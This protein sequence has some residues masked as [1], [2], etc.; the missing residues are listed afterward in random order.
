MAAAVSSAGPHGEWDG[1]GQ[2]GQGEWGSSVCPSCRSRHDAPGAV[3][4]KDQGETKRQLRALRPAAPPERA[5]EPLPGC[6]AGL[7][8]LT[9]LRSALAGFH[10][11]GKR[12]NARDTA[13]LFRWRSG[14]VSNLQDQVFCRRNRNNKREEWKS[15]LCET[16]P[17]IL[18]G[19][20]QL[21][22]T[23]QNPPKP[24]FKAETSTLNIGW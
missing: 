2:G 22:P 21:N 8:R 4:R 17:T 9:L 12:T 1:Q 3:I 18:S 13:H 15:W 16:N 14:S 6:R 10:G 7:L 5:G 11:N 23:A 19:E 20:Q 24:P